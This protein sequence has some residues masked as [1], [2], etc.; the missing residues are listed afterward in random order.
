[1]NVGW[2]SPP[3]TQR[4]GHHHG[5]SLSLVSHGPSLL[6]PVYSLNFSRSHLYFS[7][8]LSSSPFLAFLVPFLISSSPFSAEL[9]QGYRLQS[10]LDLVL[11]LLRTFSVGSK[12]A[13]PV[14]GLPSAPLCPYTVWSRVPSP[15][16]LPFSCMFL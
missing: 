9:V 10:K 13:P 8:F 6:V 7:H 14:P 1:M 15:L 16:Y 12:G 4:P 2:A 11:P 5:S 3:C